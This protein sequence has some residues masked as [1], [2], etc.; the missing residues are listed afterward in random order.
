M[1]F[2]ERF[3]IMIDSL[4]KVKPKFKGTAV[5]RKSFKKIVCPPHSEKDNRCFIAKMTLHNLEAY[6][7][8]DS[9]CMSDSISPEFTTSAN[10][11]AHE[12]EEPVPLQ[13]GTVGS[14][15]KINFRLFTDFEIGKASGSHYF[16]IININRYDAILGTIFM[17]KHGIT[18]DFDR[19]E[20]R[21]KGKVLNT[22]VEGESTFKQAHRHA[23]QPTCQK[24][25]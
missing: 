10:L 20:V 14:C 25:E 12:L 13:L 5:L 4:I 22:I 21:I 16:D 19:D 24:E 9:G 2:K 6:V 8:L 11:K 17:R 18:L 1:T 7:L 15:S 3:G 23:M